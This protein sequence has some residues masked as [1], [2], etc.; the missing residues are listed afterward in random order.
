MIMQYFIERSKSSL[1]SDLIRGSL[2]VRYGLAAVKCHDD[3]CSYD[4]TISWT[5]IKFAS[6]TP[7]WQVAHGA[8]QI[9]PDSIPG[10]Q[11]DQSPREV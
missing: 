6:V 10:T 5:R 11:A 7:W 8:L 4:R 1:R 9:G 2:V 3:P